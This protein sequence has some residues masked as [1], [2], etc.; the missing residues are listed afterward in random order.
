MGVNCM[1][2][3]KSS[4]SCA[5]YNGGR[6]AITRDFFI[7]NKAELLGKTNFMR[8]VLFVLKTMARVYKTMGGTE[9]VLG[10]LI[11]TMVIVTDGS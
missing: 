10:M 5:V 4:R 2:V 7:Y 9:R 11:Y 1:G 3:R 8:A 6:S